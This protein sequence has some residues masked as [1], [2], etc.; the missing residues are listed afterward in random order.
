MGRQIKHVV[1]AILGSAATLVCLFFAY[2]TVRLAYVNLFVD[3]A[4][5]HRTGGMLFG[6]MVFPI[7]TVLSGVSGYRLLERSIRKR[8]ASK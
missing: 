8:P 7:V 5:I 4:A 3:D 1:L 2:Y 6:A